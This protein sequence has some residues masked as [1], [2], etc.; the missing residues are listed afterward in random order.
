MQRFYHFQI[1]K[2]NELENGDW[3]TAR[4]NV[5]FWGIGAIFWGWGRDHAKCEKKS[6][7]TYKK[8]SYNHTTVLAEKSITEFLDIPLE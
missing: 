6:L 5:T 7:N 2:G 8:K 1:L 4:N 3:G